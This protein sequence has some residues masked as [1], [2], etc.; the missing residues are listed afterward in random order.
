M[1]ELLNK[2]HENEDITTIKFDVNTNG[3]DVIVTFVQAEYSNQNKWRKSQVLTDIFVTRC[4]LLNAY[5]QLDPTGEKTIKYI[6][7]NF[8]KEN[9]IEEIKQLSKHCNNIS[10]SLPTSMHAHNRGIPTSTRMLK[11]TFLPLIVTINNKDESRVFWD[12]DMFESDAVEV[13][14]NALVKGII[15]QSNNDFVDFSNIIELHQE[16]FELKRNNLTL[17]K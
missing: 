5:C 3:K 10:I 11:N 13:A 12:F 16:L 2:K 14:Y 9:V 4:N 8:L 15:P 1:I 7:E 6:T 17:E